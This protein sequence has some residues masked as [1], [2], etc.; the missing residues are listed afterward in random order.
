MDPEPNVE[1][2]FLGLVEVDS[3]TLILGDP[4]YCLPDARQD[5]PGIEYQKVIDAEQAA[6]TYLGGQPVFLLSNFG[7]DGSYPVHAQVTDTGRLLSITIEFVEPEEDDGHDLGD[8][9]G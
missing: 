7:G 8:D 9:V 2:R 5:K 6:A 1:R 4:M 3:G